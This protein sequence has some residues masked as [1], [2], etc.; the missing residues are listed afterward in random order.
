MV[1]KKFYNL[2]FVGCS[3]FYENKAPEINKRQIKKNNK[4]EIENCLNCPYP[5]CKHGNCKRVRIVK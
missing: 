4:I 1:Q 2:A 5:E 3:A